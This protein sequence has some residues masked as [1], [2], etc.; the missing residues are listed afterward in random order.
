MNTIPR[1]VVADDVS[2]RP[3]EFKRDF[4][5]VEKL[6][7]EL[8]QRI[9][10]YMYTP[11]PGLVGDVRLIDPVTGVQYDHTSIIRE[12]DGFSWSSAVIYMFE[13]YDIRLSDEFLKL[14]E[15]PDK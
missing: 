15:N 12:R 3:G 11:P 4:T 2:F 6:P 10:D 1:T 7:A 9:L 13:H 8:K 5:M 14:F